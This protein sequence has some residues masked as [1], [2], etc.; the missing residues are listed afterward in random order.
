MYNQWL[1]YQ[2]IHNSQ[3][4]PQCL[5]LAHDEADRLHPADG[6]HNSRLLKANIR[7][8]AQGLTVCFGPARLQN[9]CIR[10]DHSSHHKADLQIVLMAADHDLALLI[11]RIQNGVQLLWAASRHPLALEVVA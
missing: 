8:S 9:I 3:S 7:A 2:V 4:M 5:L 6:T 1:Q 11:Q 10:A